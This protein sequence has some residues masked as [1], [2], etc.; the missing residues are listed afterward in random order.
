[1]EFSNGSVFSLSAEFLRIHSP[2]AD[3]KVR[4]IRGEK[5][6]TSMSCDK[7]ILVLLFAHSR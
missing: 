5:V 4:S 7:C 6:T 2:A 3:G 1:M